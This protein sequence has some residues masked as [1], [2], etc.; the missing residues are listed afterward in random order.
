MTRAEGN[1]LIERARCGADVPEWQITLALQV[2]GDLPAGNPLTTRPEPV[3]NPAHAQDTEPGFCRFPSGA[4][5]VA[6][7][8]H[9]SIDPRGVPVWGA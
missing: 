2:T 3:D 4:P 7:P 1:R 8:H 6:V 9:A 5:D